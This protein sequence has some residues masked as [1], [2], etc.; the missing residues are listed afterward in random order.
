MASWKLE[1]K[2]GARELPELL[3]RLAAALESGAQ[4]DFCGLPEQPRKLVLVAEAKDGSLEV[5]LKAKREGELRV[6]TKKPAP[7]VAAPQAKSAEPARPAKSDK[8]DKSAPDAR[9]REKYR[10]LKKSMQADY[11]ALRRAAEDG[12]MPAQDQLESFLALSEA[13]AGAEQPVKE[14][15]GPE[16]AELAQ[17]NAAFVQDALALRRAFSGRDAKALLDVLD[18]LERRKS[19]CHAQFR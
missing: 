9:A 13:M 10:Q 11:K 2:L 15:R 17:A 14:P 18:R 5:K 7:A 8:P 12:R 4:G 1:K 3:R 16:A 6:P 19:A